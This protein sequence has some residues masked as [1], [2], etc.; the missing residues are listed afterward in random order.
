MDAVY[1]SS[2]HRY[3]TDY[4]L[5][6][7]RRTNVETLSLVTKN[8]TKA[9]QRIINIVIVVVIRVYTSVRTHCSHPPH[10]EGKKPTRSIEFIQEVER[11]RGTHPN[12]NRL[13]HHKRHH[14][15]DFTANGSRVIEQFPLIG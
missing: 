8:S 2:I 12:A 4:T 3:T 1:I 14:I 6:H 5:T 10:H 15:F 7:I 9:R 11:Y 13:L